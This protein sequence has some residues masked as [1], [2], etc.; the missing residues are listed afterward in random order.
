MP[1]IHVSNKLRENLKAGKD[2]PPPDLSEVPGLGH[3]NAHLVFLGGKKCLIFINEKTSYCL[4][5]PGVQKKDIQ[6]LAGLFVPELLTWLKRDGMYNLQISNAIL[7]EYENLTISRTN[8]SKK[9]IG[10]MNDRVKVVEYGY[11]DGDISY[12]DWSRIGEI[13]DHFIWQGKKVVQP[14]NLMRDLVGTLRG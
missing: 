12:A 9:V 8:N 2:L 1:S 7:A 10:L 13:N 6:D 3:W 11:H 14:V 5:I 4:F